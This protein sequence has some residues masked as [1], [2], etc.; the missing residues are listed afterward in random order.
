MIAHKSMADVLTEPRSL[1]RSRELLIAL[2]EKEC[3]LE[4]GKAV[5]QDW[6]QV[7]N[8]SHPCC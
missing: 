5:A 6:R 2:T 7:R 3:W 1:V 4:F 8:V